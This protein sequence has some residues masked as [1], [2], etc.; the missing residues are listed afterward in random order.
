VIDPIM[1]AKEGYIYI[2]LSNQTPSSDV[3]FDDL[4][5][6]HIQNRVIQKN[7]YYPFGLSIAGLNSNRENALANN[8]LYNGKELQVEFNLGWLDYRARMYDASIGRWMATDGKAELYFANSPYNYALNTP[9]NAIDPDGNLVIFINGLGGGG[10]NYWKTTKYTPKYVGHVNV[11]M[12]RHTIEFDELV[13]NQLNDHHAEYID[14]SPSYLASNISPFFRWA[15]GFEDG[16]NMAAQLIESLAR[17]SQ[18]NI[19][20][21]IKII[22]HSMGGVYAKG[23]VLAIKNYIRR[24]T[25]PQIKKVLISLVADFDP[26]QAGTSYGE[27]DPDIHTLQFINSGWWDFFNAGWLANQEEDGAEKV[28]DNEN[29]TSHFI[30]TFVDNISDLKK[31]TY[32]WNE[33][34]QRW[35]CTSCN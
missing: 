26:F 32:E 16:N 7:D 21:S 2:Y 10:K 3:Y 24:S 18:G 6:S 29:K 11:G 35:V 33:E 30:E 28:K 23:F 1:I 34:K 22:T 20:E 31:G 13:M 17:D 9:V 5:V 14:G 15:Q 27:A 8:Y 4:M 25:D 19:T 12:S